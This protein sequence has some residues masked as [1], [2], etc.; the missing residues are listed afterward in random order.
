MQKYLIILL[1]ILFASCDKK[2]NLD[3]Q[4]FQTK[5]ERISDSSTRQ[6]YVDKFLKKISKKDYPIFENDSTVVLLY[7]GDVNKVDMI[8]DINF[9]TNPCRFNNIDGTNLFFLRMNI[10]KNSLLEYWLIIDNEKTQI[11]SL[12]SYKVKNEFGFASQIVNHTNPNYLHQLKKTDEKLYKTFLVPLENNKYV[13]FHI[14]FPPQYNDYDN[15][16][17]AIFLDGKKYI[18]FG[19]APEIIE[20]LIVD[21]KINK[22]IAVF[23][24]IGFDIDNLQNSIPKINDISKIISNNLLKYIENK[25]NVLNNPDDRLLIGKSF[26]SS[27]N[28]LTAIKNSDK[29]GNVFSQS[30]YLSAEKYMLNNLIQENTKQNIKFYFQIGIYERNVSHMIIPP[31]ET[32][33]YQINYDFVDILKSK[34][35]NVKIDKYRAGHTWGNWKNNLSDGLIYFFKKNASNPG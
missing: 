17:L 28:I 27:V 26:A 9:W 15:Y 1:L 11:D 22:I 30:G 21:D 33:F 35:Y 23:V 2:Y 18:E 12:N 16:P 19:N 4:N 32:D 29:F 14:Y 20:D 34:N 7:K 8:G 25:F 31:S 6:S 24:E 10:I 3:F 13:K 5:I